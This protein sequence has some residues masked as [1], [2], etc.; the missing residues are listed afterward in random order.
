MNQKYYKK[1]IAILE[2]HKLVY[3]PVYLAYT[4]DDELGKF[5]KGKPQ[6]LG[7]YANMRRKTVPF[8][9]EKHKIKK[10]YYFYKWQK[11]PEQHFNSY[12]KKF[13]KKQE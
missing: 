3:V 2:T 9:Y 13:Q 10:I 4:Y 7:A 6:G 5:K 12:I 11:I 1:Q 8:E